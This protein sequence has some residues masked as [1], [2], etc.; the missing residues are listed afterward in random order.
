MLTSIAVVVHNSAAALRAC[1]SG[2]AGGFEVLVVDAGSTDDL[3]AVQREFPGVRWL[4]MENRGYAAAVNVALAQATGARFVFA[5]ADVRLTGALVEAL[6]APLADP[7]VGLVAPHVRC[8]GEVRSPLKPA[9]AFAWDAVAAVLPV[10][11]RDAVRN[12][13]RL[14]APP[15]S[16]DG[17][18]HAVR[19]E[20]LRALGGLDESFFLYFE[21]T[22]LSA[23]VRATGR[24]LVACDEVLEH[25]GGASRSRP[26]W[27]RRLFHRS[28]MRYAQLTG[29]TPSALAL[30]ALSAAGGLL[31]AG[32]HLLAGRRPAA[33]DSLD[34]A[35][36]AGWWVAD[37]LLGRRVESIQLEPASG[38]QRTIN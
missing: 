11:W 17:P 34:R 31:H 19:T 5:N 7:A 33:R 28:R 13:L 15:L 1:L 30:A 3:A 32:A 18:C 20:D 12:A 8:E 24:Q 6:T 14:A 23:R 29:G 2:L 35:R 10:R 25:E 22:H 27:L 21:E 36:G 26:E 38:H 37:T 9:P 16:L 4:R